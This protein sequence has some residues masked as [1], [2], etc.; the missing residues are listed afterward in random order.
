MLS[1]TSIIFCWSHSHKYVTWNIADTRLSLNLKSCQGGSPSSKHKLWHVILYIKWILPTSSWE[2]ALAKSV[3][4]LLS[5]YVHKCM[6][7][8]WYQMNCQQDKGVAIYKHSQ[9][10]DGNRLHKFS[11]SNKHPNPI[12]ISQLNTMK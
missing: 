5:G 2:N 10:R 12:P 9:T 4:L 11:Q 1:T 8:Y 3:V 7:F 6:L